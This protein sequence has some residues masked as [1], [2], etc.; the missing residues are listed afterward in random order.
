VARRLC[1][2]WAQHLVIVIPL[3]IGTMP[4]LLKGFFEQTVRPGFAM[5]LTRDVDQAVIWP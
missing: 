3:W 5:A 1:I 4:A 2:R